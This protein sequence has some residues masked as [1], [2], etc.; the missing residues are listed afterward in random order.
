MPLEDLRVG[1]DQRIQQVPGLLLG[2]AKVSCK[3]FRAIGL[4]WGEM[5]GGV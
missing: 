5:K 3:V 1:G 4:H 2:D